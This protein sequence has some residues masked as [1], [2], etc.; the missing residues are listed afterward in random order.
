MLSMVNDETEMIKKHPAMTKAPRTIRSMYEGKINIPKSPDDKDA[1]ALDM[2]KELEHGI[3]EA[4]D[5]LNKSYRNR[6]FKQVQSG[7]EDDSSRDGSDYNDSY[8]RRRTGRR[9]YRDERDREDINKEDRY[10][11]DR[12]R[13]DRYTKDRRPK[14]RY[15][16]DYR[17]GRRRDSR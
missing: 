12:R 2:I 17:N 1:T 16:D 13:G 4:Q 9:K 14:D 10:R 15:R 8:E 6:F 7:M 11:K 5:K 3:Q